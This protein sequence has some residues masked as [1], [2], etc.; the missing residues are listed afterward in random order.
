MLVNQTTAASRESSL[1]DLAV[2]V[3]A[4][5]SQAS[6][7]AREANLLEEFA[8]LVRH[9][10]APAE[11]KPQ[12]KSSQK[13]GWKRPKEAKAALGIGTTAFYARINDG[14]L[15]TMKLGRARLVWVEVPE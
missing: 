4:L 12:V 6:A 3:A 13:S 9:T 10:P 15:R 11:P 8:R 7:L 14:S 2:K 1:A 5:A